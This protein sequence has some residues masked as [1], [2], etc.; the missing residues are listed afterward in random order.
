MAKRKFEMGDK[1]VSKREI[2]KEGV[3]IDFH[4]ET[5]EYEI[6][7]ENGLVHYEAPRWLVK[8]QD[9]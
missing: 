6:R 8:K 3:V 7:L 1:V 2:E 4:K 5:G 9:K